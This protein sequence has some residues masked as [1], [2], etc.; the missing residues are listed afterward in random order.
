MSLFERSLSLSTV[1]VSCM[2]SSTLNRNWSQEGYLRAKGFSMAGY[3]GHDPGCLFVYTR[4]EVGTELVSSYLRTSR[5]PE[6]H[7]PSRE[8][9]LNQIVYK[10]VH[11]ES[12]HQDSLQD[13]AKASHLTTV[14]C[15]FV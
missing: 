6:S 1:V 14:Y 11:I 10:F 8:S 2:S 15:L 3:D 13:K 7:Q 9:L 5:L 4:G 12:L